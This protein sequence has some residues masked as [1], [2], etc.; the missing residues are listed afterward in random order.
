MR[1]YAYICLNDCFD[2]VISCLLK[3]AY[4][5]IRLYEISKILSYNLKEHETAFFSVVP[6]SI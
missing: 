3:G 5:I 2:I 1:E 6:G 4:T